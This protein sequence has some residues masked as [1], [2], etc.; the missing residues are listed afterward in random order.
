MKFFGVVVLVVGNCFN[1]DQCYVRNGVVFLV[2][3]KMNLILGYFLV[4]FI[5]I[6]LVIVWLVLKM[7]LVVNGG[8]VSCLLGVLIGMVG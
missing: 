2:W 6:R 1:K 8:M 4:I 5:Q 3:E 7:N